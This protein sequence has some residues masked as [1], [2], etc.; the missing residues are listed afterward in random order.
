MPRSGTTWVGKIFDSHP[1]T[2]YRHE[3][4]SWGRLNAI[5]LLAPLDESDKYKGLIQSFVDSLP[6]MNETKVAASTPL[7]PK[8]YYSNVVFTARTQLVS[9]AKLY[10]KVFGEINVP[11]LLSKN[12][13]NDAV[14]VWKSIESLGRLGVISKNLPDVK[15]VHI[16]RHPCGYVASVLRGEAQS[17]F[18]GGTP[19]SEDYGMLE[20][21]LETEQAKRRNLSFEYFKSLVPVER[22]AWR[23]TLFNEKAIEETRESDNIKI[24]KYEDLCAEPEKVARDLFM[25]MGLDW[26]SQ[27]QR[28]LSN[29]TKTEKDSYYSVFKNPLKSA[30]KWQSELSGD[31]VNK[32]YKILKDT[33][34]GKLYS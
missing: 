26:P 6:Y 21:L 24:L 30:N 23:W 5:P 9:F 29:S 25:A 2:L 10:A 22:L 28:F 18:T 34:P 15:G 14:I 12:G 3:P 8:S 32:I 11:S 31:E 1:V 16:I 17:R 20:M 7:F 4:D 19:T 13:L 33:A 27:T